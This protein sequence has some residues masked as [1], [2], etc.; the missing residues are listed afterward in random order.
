M[1]LTVVR[2]EFLAALS[3]AQSV[4]EKRSTVPV[5]SHVLLVAEGNK[6]QMTA[7]DLDLTIVE[8]IIADV[9]IAGTTTVPAYTLYEIVRRLEDGNDVNLTLDDEGKSLSITS[10]RSAFRLACLAPDDF[11]KIT[12]SD[13]PFQFSIPASQLKQLLDRTHFAMSIEETR[14]YLNGV[15]L[16]PINV[17]GQL[18][19]R[20]VASDSH[21]LALA[22]VPCPVGAENI[23]GVI[24]SRKTVHELR[25]LLDNT[26]TAILVQLSTNQVQFEMPNCILSA[27][28]V[29]GT[30]PNYDAVIPANNN[31]Q[32]MVPT[33]NFMECVGRVSTVL[34]DKFRGIKLRIGGNSLAM[35]AVN[36]DHGQ[37][38]DEAEIESDVENLEIGFNAKY[39]TDITHQISGDKM[40]VWVDDMSSPAI[41]KDEKDASA[42]YVL[43][44][45]RV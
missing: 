45:M 9:E 22:E 41:F 5:L 20:A 24:L 30:F 44:P 34:N 2:N 40:A 7:T 8:T 26:T 21:R 32:F 43:M 4:V 10:K 17:N 39:L 12:R 28:L 38:A 33:K 27:R 42:L 16:H 23:P 35:I 6:L 18:M 11:P 36:P 13:L 1:K 15:Y 37:A 25:R 14:Y 31:R 29:D 3:H 19:L